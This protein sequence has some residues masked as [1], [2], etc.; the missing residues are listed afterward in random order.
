MAE[1]GYQTDTV[2]YARSRGYMAKRNYMAPGCEVGWPDVEIFLP[3]GRVVLI[4]FK[5]PGKAPRK[6]QAH[7]AHSLRKLGH[8]VATCYSLDEAKN[9]IDSLASL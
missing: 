9:I 2:N 8:H 3:K 7:R 1:A 5:S 6:I 4:E